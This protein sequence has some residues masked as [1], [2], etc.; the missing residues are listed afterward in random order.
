[1]SVAR[2][3]GSIMTDLATKQSDPQALVPRPRVVEDSQN[4]ITTLKK[5]LLQECAAMLHYALDKD[6]PI[7]ADVSKQAATALSGSSLADDPVSFSNMMALHSQLS[8]IIT[9]ASG[10]TLVLFEIERQT[11]PQL[12]AFG[13]VR[14]VRQMVAFAFFAL[15]MTGFLSTTAPVDVKNVAAGWFNLHG[16]VAYAVLG[17][18][19]AVA[20]LGSAFSNLAIISHYIEDATFDPIFE[21]SY[22]VRA[23]LGLI[24]G[25]VLGEIL[26][27]LVA[28]G[29]ATGGLVTASERIVMTFLGGFATAPVQK[30]L[31][32]L[33]DAVGTLLQGRD[34]KPAPV[35]RTTVSAPAS[36]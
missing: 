17:F 4:P 24:S 36:E 2:V 6:K 29:S 8:A 13:P 35:P 5:A 34:A 9:P 20:S 15:L 11:H 19:F 10:R 12:Y 21:G 30:L 22:W 3:G 27:D 1:A 23:V 31:G 28:Q 25:V 26:F 33:S 14:V 18:L 32:N 7:P 16:L